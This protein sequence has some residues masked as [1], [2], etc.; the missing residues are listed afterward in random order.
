M[1]VWRIKHFF[2]NKKLINTKTVLNKLL[3]FIHRYRNKAKELS[4]VW[5]DRPLSPMD[6]AIFWIEYVARHKGAVNLKP[7]TVDMPLYQYLMLDAIFVV[8]AVLLIILFIGVTVVSL[9]H[10]SFTQGTVEL[11]YSKKQKI[12]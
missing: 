11:Q 8:V 10:K 2:L 5:K 3:F 9:I 4:R 6:T 1:F 12:N 7:P